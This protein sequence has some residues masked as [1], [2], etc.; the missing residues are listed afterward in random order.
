MSRGF[1][2][3]WGGRVS[4]EEATEKAMLLFRL[5]AS[6]ERRRACGFAGV[7]LAVVHLLLELLRLLL[8][9]KAEPGNAF[10]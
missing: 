5:G 9:D 4:T 1:G 8:V 10:F 7:L 3:S 6:S 2:G